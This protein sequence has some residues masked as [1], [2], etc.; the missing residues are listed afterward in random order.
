MHQKFIFFCYLPAYHGD[1][2]N[3]DG[4]GGVLAHTFLPGIKSING[5]IHMDNAEKWNVDYDIFVVALHEI[6]HSIGLY[7]S[8]YYNSVMYA[9][10]NKASKLLKLD[11]RMGV[12][13]LYG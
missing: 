5:D 3:F 10:Y 12:E 9:Q 2:F 11:D 1:G 7:H 8:K 13:A 4:Q 6:G